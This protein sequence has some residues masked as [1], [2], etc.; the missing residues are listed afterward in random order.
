MAKD[1][2]NELSYQ[3]LSE[4]VLKDNETQSALKEAWIILKTVKKTWNEELYNK[5]SKN[6]Q[7][8]YNLIIDSKKSEAQI[9]ISERQQIILELSEMIKLAQNSQIDDSESFWA[10]L[11]DSI[12]STDLT[13]IK[14]KSEW[15]RGKDIS[16]YSLDD[17]IWA[18]TFLNRNYQNYKEI[19]EK[20]ISVEKWKTPTETYEQWTPK[21]WAIFLSQL[22]WQSSPQ[23]KNQESTHISVQWYET[24]K[25]IDKATTF[26][27]QSIDDLD[28]KFEVNKFSE[29][30]INKVLWKPENYKLSEEAWFSNEYLH[31]YN[32]Q[33]WNKIYKITDF[34]NELKTKDIKDINSKALANYFLYLQSKWN[35]NEEYLVNNFPPKILMWLWNLWDKWWDD[36]ITK[37]I[38]EKFELNDFIETVTVFRSTESI[39]EQIKIMFEN[40][41]IPDDKKFQ[42]G[43]T[44]TLFIHKCSIE[45]VQEVWT[46]ISNMTNLKIDSIKNDKLLTEENKQQKI[47]LLLLAKENLI[48]D[49]SDWLNKD[50]IDIK[51]LVRKIWAFGE[52][53]NVDLPLREYYAAE[54][55][56]D[57][58]IKEKEHAEAIIEKQQIESEL[59]TKTEVLAIA[60]IKWDTDVANKL[61]K[62]IKDLKKEVEVSKKEVIISWEKANLANIKVTTYNQ[63]TVD[64][65]EDLLKWKTT[66]EEVAQ[67]NRAVNEYLD[68]K[69]RHYE[70]ISAYN[71]K[72]LNWVKEII[73]N[74]EKKKEDEENN[75]SNINWKHNDQELASIRRENY[76][77]NNFVNTSNWVLY[78]TW[79]NW[80]VYKP[81]SVDLKLQENRKYKQ[82][83][84]KFVL[85][86]NELWANDFREIR[87]EIFW[88]IS[89]LKWWEALKPDSQ[90]FNKQDTIN[91]LSLIIKSAW[92]NPNN[93][94]LEDIKK[95]FD[96]LNKSNTAFKG[97]NNKS[98]NN[99]FEKFKELYFVEWRLDTIKLEKALRQPN[100]TNNNPENKTK[101]EAVIA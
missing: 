11:W 87:E 63:A 16:Q 76:E 42:L 85:T 88:V 26:F 5:F 33:E 71:N 8:L 92:F 68:K 28:D 51:N 86:L 20:D 17:S 14:T 57:A 60:K 9:S 97:L 59:N 61:D 18:I 49:I 72:K 64:Q 73:E 98:N 47:E 41:D 21:N 56:A 90:K 66:F 22:N 40:K 94:T 55:R 83:L 15:L 54:L 84:N 27:Y 99:L 13:D 34:E 44:L 65:K 3:T 78:K 36:L 100:N 12:K 53:N 91:F 24:E 95:Q 62:E 43:K 96:E 77:H 6:Y 35:L 46:S 7:E 101:K 80:I 67:K 32:N 2:F 10:R 4:S 75:N 58:A 89:N 50:P 93:W 31:W 48:K 81:T 52:W 37:N 30:A 69:L 70:N 1:I 82:N 38:L 29:K 39:V 23:N 45:I 74:E 79:E 19:W 25:N